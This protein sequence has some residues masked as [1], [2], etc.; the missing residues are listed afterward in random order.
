M[1]SMLMQCFNVQGLEDPNALTLAMSAMQAC[2]LIGLP[3]CGLFLAHV[4]THLARSVSLF[5]PLFFLFP[6][7][8]KPEKSTMQLT[9][10]ANC[11]AMLWKRSRIKERREVCW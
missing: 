3:E 1:L 10:K 8:K 11:L 6:E 2:K 5:V 7:G 4:A 9:S